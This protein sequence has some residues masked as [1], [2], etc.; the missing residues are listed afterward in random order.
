MKYH[1]NMFIKIYAHTVDIKDLK[2]IQVEP[3]NS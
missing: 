1:G 3:Q 2:L